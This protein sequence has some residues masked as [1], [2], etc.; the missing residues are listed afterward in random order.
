MMIHPAFYT[1]GAVLAVAFLVL[2]LWRAREPPPPPRVTATRSWL[3]DVPEHWKVREA[4]P[5]PA[6][7]K[8]LTNPDVPD[9]PPLH[10][11]TWRDVRREERK[12]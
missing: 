8:N 7:T 9:I 12:R 4:D 6:S 11:R 2:M 10:E 1:A 3:D 5:V